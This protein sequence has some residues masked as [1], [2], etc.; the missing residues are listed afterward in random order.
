MGRNGAGKSTLLRLLAGLM[1]PD[2]RSR[3]WSRVPTPHALPRIA[4][5]CARSGSSHPIRARCCYERTIAS[6]CAVADREHRL[7]AGTTRATLDRI[8][9]GLDPERH[10]RDLLGRPTAGAGA[11]GRARPRAAA[12]PAR[13]ADAR[14]RLRRPRR[15]SPASLA[16]AR[17]GGSRSRARHPRRRARR[18]DREPR[19]RDRR[20]RNRGRRP[21]TRG[22]VSLAGVRAAGGQDPRAR[23]NGSRS[24]R[25]RRRSAS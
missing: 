7:P 8:E 10:P 5:S 21:G 15:A 22:R 17:G 11:R 3:R 13:R 2:G 23:P 9:P 25:Y 1:R 12:H 6:E 16:R 19:H 24:T 20:R 14:P 18:R 4:H